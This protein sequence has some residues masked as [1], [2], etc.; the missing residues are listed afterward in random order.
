MARRGEDK[1]KCGAKRVPCTL[2]GGGTPVLSAPG[3]HWA[4]TLDQVLFQR[5]ARNRTDEEA[6]ADRGFARDDLARGRH[7]ALRRGV[8]ALALRPGFGALEAKVQEGWQR[9]EVPH[10]RLRLLG[11]FRLQREGEAQSAVFCV[12]RVPYYFA[13]WNFGQH[14]C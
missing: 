1:A 4:H 8:E 13:Q 14:L 6:W 11:T 10:Q 9:R 5:A 3:T 7:T 12:K 2:G